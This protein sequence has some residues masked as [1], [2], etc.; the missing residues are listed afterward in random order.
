ATLAQPVGSLIRAH[1]VTGAR[2]ITLLALL[3][4]VGIVTLIAFVPLSRWTVHA[5]GLPSAARRHTLLRWQHLAAA[6]LFVPL[7][8]TWFTMTAEVT[9]VIEQGVYEAWKLQP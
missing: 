2:L 7:F 4:A 1:F 6:A 8:F 3:L 5:L 9:A